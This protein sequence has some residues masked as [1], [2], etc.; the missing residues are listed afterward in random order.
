MKLLIDDANIEN[1]K[2]IYRYYPIDGV[3][4]N[5]SILLKNGRNPYDVLKEIRE[6]IGDEAQLH[7]QVISKKAEDM[8]TEG[9]KIR[10]ELG[11]KTYIKV[12]AVREGLRAMKILSKEGCRI[13]ATAVYTPMQAFLS[14]KA[15]ADYA[16]PYVNRIDNL[17]F[18]GTDAAK[19]IHDMFIRNELKTKVLA[20][21]FKNSRQVLE[22]CKYGIGAATLGPDVIEGLMKNAGVVSAVDDFTADFE[23]LCG[24]GKTMLD[25]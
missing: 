12:P 10:N 8:V 13:T 6:F 9:R 21:S 18:S 16:A 1:I 14:G 22:L 25:C 19:T 4:T 3:T 15:G 11:D 2:E 23:K 7:V 24:E 5:P 20:A 17:G